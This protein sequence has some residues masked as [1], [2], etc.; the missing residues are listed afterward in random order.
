MIKSKIVSILKS[1]TAL[2]KYKAER[3]LFIKMGG[4][5]Q[6]N[7]PILNEFSEQSGIA[8]GHYFHQD[9][10]V[11]QFIF[12]K[13][14]RV[15]VDIG[16]RTDGFVAHVASFRKIHIFDIRPLNVLSHPNILYTYGDLVVGIGDNLADS[17]SCLHSIEHFGLGRYGDTINPNGHKLAFD[18]L[19]NMLEPQGTLYISFPISSADE[20]Y[21]NAHRVFHP[22]SIFTWTQKKVKLIRFDYVDDNGDLKKDYDIINYDVDV[23]YGC[24]IYTFEKL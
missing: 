15:H 22:R 2:K 23:K 12:S 1:R 7:F 4:V 16:S 9:L 8:N 18:N 11:A 13:N 14:P 3:N 21:F 17:I 20:V 24:G 5:I 10:L 6:H 19:L